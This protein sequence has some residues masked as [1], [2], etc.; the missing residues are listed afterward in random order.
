VSVNV[1]QVAN[2]EES[3][4]SLALL[5]ELADVLA[6]LQAAIV[7]Y[8]SAR[9]EYEAMMHAERERAR[10]KEALEVLARL[11]AILALPTAVVAP[12]YPT[13]VT[14]SRAFEDVLAACAPWWGLSIG[15]AAAITAFLFFSRSIA[16]ALVSIAVVTMIVIASKPRVPMRRALCGAVIGVSF[17]AFIAMTS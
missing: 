4:N 5:H 10:E 3:P 14:T 9:A 11:E 12:A 7:A 16:L 15:G 1:S 8:E 6:R 2:R 13:Q 17:G